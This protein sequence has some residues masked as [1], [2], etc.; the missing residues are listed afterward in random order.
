MTRTMEQMEKFFNTAGPGTL[1][2]HYMVDPLRRIDYDEIATLI[3][4]KR[5]FVLHAPRQ[6]GKTTSLLAMV[7]KIN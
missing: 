1:E 2:D 5:Y 3:E 7:K 4:R 6:T